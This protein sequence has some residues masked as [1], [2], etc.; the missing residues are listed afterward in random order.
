MADLVFKV[1]ADYDE[2]IRLREELARLREEMIKTASASDEQKEHMEKLEEQ[3]AE[4]SSKLNGLVE[5]AAESAAEMSNNYSLGLAKSSSEYKTMIDALKG[6]EDGVRSFM[7]EKQRNGELDDETAKKMRTLIYVIQGVQAVLKA[8]SGAQAKAAEAT[9]SSASASKEASEMQKRW[10]KATSAAAV[11]E[12]KARI[13]SELAAEAKEKEAYH[14]EILAEHERTQTNVIKGLSNAKKGAAVASTQLATSEAAASGAAKGLSTSE[15]AATGATTGFAASE[16]V[17]TGTT[18]GFAASVRSLSAAMSANPVGL[19]L[20]LL[21]IA[22]SLISG[23]G[24]ATDSTTSEVKG[25][26]DELREELKNLES[27]FDTIENTS[28]RTKAH[29]DA[30][31]EVNEMCKEYNISLL[32]E[33]DTL[34]QQKIKY[35]QLEAAIRSANAAKIGEKYMSAAEEKASKR[36]DTSLGWLKFRASASGIRVSDDVWAQIAL[37]TQNDVEELSQL[38]GAAYESKKKK[39][40][41]D[42]QD[43]IKANSNASDKDLRRLQ[44]GLEGYVTQL[45]KTQRK[46][47]TRKKEIVAS[48]E[49]FKNEAEKTTIDIDKASFDQLEAAFDAQA[50]GLDNLTTE[51]LKAGEKAQKEEVAAKMTEK[52]AQGTT[53]ELKDRKS[54]L[55]KRIEEMEEGSE[56]QTQLKGMV[57]SID[58]ELKTRDDKDDTPKSVKDRERAYKR[59]GNKIKDMIRS[60]EGEINK[61]RISAIEDGSEAVTEQ[62]DEQKRLLVDKANEIAEEMKSVTGAEY[63]ELKASYDKLMDLI[64]QLDQLRRGNYQKQLDKKDEEYRQSYLTQYGSWEEKR[65]A[66]RD[67]YQKMR[68]KRGKDET[69]WE[70]KLRDIQEKNEL[71]AVTFEEKAY[72]LMSAQRGGSY[73]DQKVA[74]EE[75]YDVQIEAAKALNQKAKAAELLRQKEDALFDLETKFNYSDLFGDITRYTE[76]QLATAKALGDE[77]LKSGKFTIEQAKAVKEALNKIEDTQ[78]TN[79]YG[80]RLPSLTLNEFLSETENLKKLKAQRLAMRND[81]SGIFTEEDYKKIEDRIDQSEFRLRSG[82]VNGIG[83][84]LSEAA[85]YMRELADATGDVHLEELANAAEG[86]AFSFDTM[87]AAA[88][89]DWSSVIINVVSTVGKAIAD[90]VK[91][92]K[93][94]EL[95]VKALADSLTLMNLS[96]DSDKFFSIFGSGNTFSAIREYSRLAEDSSKELSDALGALYSADYKPEGKKGR[97]RDADYISRLDAYNKAV[98]AGQK[99]LQTMLVKT[100]DR[101]GVLNWLGIADKYESLHDIAPEIFNA[102][103]TLNVEKTEVF[104]QTD[105]SQYLD[106]TQKQALQNAVEL[107]KKYKEN[108]DGLKQQLASLF[109]SINN[110]LAEATMNGI[111][112]GSKIGVEYMRDQMSGI[113]EQLGVDMLNGIYS[114]YT[115]GYQ[116]K[117]LELAKSGKTEDYLKLLDEMYDGL[118]PVIETATEAAKEWYEG[119]RDK[120]FD[121]NRAKNADATSQTMQSIS[122]TTGS[123]IQGGVTALRLSSEVRNQ[124]LSIM[125]AN[126]TELLRQQSL[127]TTLAN[128]VRGIQADALIALNAIRNH[129]KDNLSSVQ[130][131]ESMVESIERRTRDKL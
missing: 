64:D 129:T 65:L 121:I 11:A 7:K 86:M 55:Q 109:G 94:L 79:K 38:S 13:E 52:A 111:K 27:L 49:Q 62:F 96:F 18:M 72:S 15:V 126:L 19:A 10:Q 31:E 39:I 21:P 77:L 35:Q 101:S 23:A 124:H 46:L 37:R 17:A 56:L 9:K 24:D 78:R 116:D 130:N 69:E 50:D 83:K 88:K 22:T 47:D 12:R 20:T 131:I 14:A 80:N 110:T 125:S 42:I 53:R 43:S 100:K 97:A 44:G 115:S 73:G 123:A 74:I 29:K 105:M 28:K 106:E 68:E 122:E 99:G 32:N 67:K 1:K 82:I 102:D 57:K 70:K 118:T 85:G 89:G 98:K 84:G 127:A 87:V 30:V 63:E 128:D 5:K 66:I 113:V 54:R 93:E 41:K 95:R 107:Q 45:D 112:N 34:E 33:N 26:N 75:Y 59:Y 61:E 6:A 71:D 104:L 60:V 120:G 119:A 92:T 90:E 76:S 25:L 3:Y 58:D 103:G 4:A 108:L 16:T 51:I 8:V 91:M 117:L 40:I 114:A 81:E 48:T 2:A 36:N